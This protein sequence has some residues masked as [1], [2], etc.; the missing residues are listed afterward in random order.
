MGKAGSEAAPIVDWRVDKTEVEEGLETIAASMTN[1]GGK[2]GKKIRK[3][4]CRK[5]V[6]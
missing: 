2:A 1:S 6:R 3:E 5:G 4:R